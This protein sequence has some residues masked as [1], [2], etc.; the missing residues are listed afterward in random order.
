MKKP[1]K[2]TIVYDQFG[3]IVSICRPAKETKVTVL[4]GNG[5]SILVTDVDEESINSLINSHHVDCTRNIL[6][7]N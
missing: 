6:V 1:L 3:R 2:V 5:E 4:S 7:Q